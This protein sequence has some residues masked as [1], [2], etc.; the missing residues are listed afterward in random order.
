M[1]GLNGSQ[2]VTLKRDQAVTFAELGR[3]RAAPPLGFGK[4]TGF[5]PRQAAPLS[6]L[7]RRVRRPG[8]SFALFARMLPAGV[9]PGPQVDNHSLRSP[10]TRRSSAFHIRRWPDC[11]CAQPSHRRAAGACSCPRRR[12]KAPTR[13]KIRTPSKVARR[14]FI[15]IKSQK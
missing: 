11:T 10:P 2:A 8:L 1:T 5:P 14:A 12:F 7:R 13:P 15:T 6:S 4:V 3:L 9:W